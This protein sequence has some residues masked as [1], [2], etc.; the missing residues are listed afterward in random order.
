MLNDIFQNIG[1]SIVSNL[2]SF[3][4]FI[5]A[6]VTVTVGGSKVSD[7]LTE[8]QER[9]NRAVFNYHTNI[10]IYVSRIK[11]LLSDSSGNMT[12]VLYLYSAN[13]TLNKK[14][15][16]YEETAKKLSLISGKF[17]DFLSSAP[18]QIPPA[19][20]KEEFDK[21]NELLEKMI[22]YLSDFQLYELNAYIPQMN[23]EPTALNYYN[24]II[25]TFDG[26]VKLIEKSKYKYLN[27]EPDS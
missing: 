20:N 7:F 13:E 12:N 16:G 5:L 23:E 18:E 15:N 4:S 11:R 19:D 22:N 27:I 2:I 14:S 3:F 25:N 17:L 26:I 10:K 21:W 8:Y 24:D 9:K 1:S 6:A